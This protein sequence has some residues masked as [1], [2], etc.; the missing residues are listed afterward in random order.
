MRGLIKGNKTKRQILL[1][2]LKQH[3]RDWKV[4]PNQGGSFVWVYGPPQ[5]DARELA[6]A[7]QDVGVLIEPG[8]AFYMSESRPLNS[9]RLGYTSIPEARIAD[10]VALIAQE[11]TKLLSV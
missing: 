8:S 9:F 4:A 3:L 1:A 7:C 6:T 11:A 2:S 10:G 5:L